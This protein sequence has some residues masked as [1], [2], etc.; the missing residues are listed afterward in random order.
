ME[1]DQTDIIKAAYPNAAYIIFAERPPR[2][3][4]AEIV[5]QSI[6][7]V[8]KEEEL[9]SDEPMRPNKWFS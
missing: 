1:S 2:E 4:P 7:D 3:P 9:D 8:T 6:F 5:L